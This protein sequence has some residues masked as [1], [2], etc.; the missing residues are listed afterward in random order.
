M[1]SVLPNL[2][3]KEIYGNMTIWGLILLK[4]GGDGRVL[5]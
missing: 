3:D 4:L 5:T 1:A 2:I